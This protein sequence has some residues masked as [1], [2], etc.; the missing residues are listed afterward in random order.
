M[1]S[2]RCRRCL[3]RSCLK[4]NGGLIHVRYGRDAVS[5]P[6]LCLQFPRQRSLRVHIGFL[7]VNRPVF[8]LIELDRLPRDRAA[9]ILSGFHHPE[10][11]IKIFK[12]GFGLW[13]GLRCLAQHLVLSRRAGIGLRHWVMACAMKAGPQIEGAI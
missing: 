10:V 13:P 2:L 8:Q 12:H 11:S 4:N 7:P 5:G 1:M 9:H 6:F 3:H